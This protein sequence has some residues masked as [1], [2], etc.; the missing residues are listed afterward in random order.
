MNAGKNGKNQSDLKNAYQ[1]IYKYQEVCA[2]SICVNSGKKKMS[3]IIF[4][5]PEIFAVA[6]CFLQN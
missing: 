5:Y 2:D 3:Q 1:K 4:I 6:F